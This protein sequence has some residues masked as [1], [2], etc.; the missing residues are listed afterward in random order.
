MLRNLVLLFL[1]AA[2]AEAQDAAPRSE[3]LVRVWQSDE[4]LPGN[5]VRS[6]GESADG[7]LWIATAEGISRFDG[8]SFRTVET[9]GTRRDRKYDYFR[10]FTPDDGSVWVATHSYGLFRVREDGLESAY[11]GDGGAEPGVV[12]RVLSHGGS[13]YF[14]R[15]GKLWRIGGNPPEA[16]DHPAP[17]LEAAFSTDVQRQ[18]QRG[19]GENKNLPELLVDRNGGEW[20]IR[21]RSLSYRAPGAASSVVVKELEGRVAATDMLEDREGSIWLANPSYGLV[22]IRHRRV[23]Q[24]PLHNGVYDSPALAAVQSKDGTWWIA[25]RNGGVDRVRDGEVFH[26][27][28]VTS[29]LVRAVACLKED[30]QG[31]LWIAT[32]DASV[33]LLN[34]ETQ[35]V[36]GQF[37]SNPELSKINVIVEDSNGR[38]WFGG[39]GRLFCWDG[40]KVESYADKP[41]LSGME[42]F[43]MAFAPSGILY[44][45]TTDGRMFTFDGHAFLPLGGLPHTSTRACIS[46][47]IPVSSGEVW[48]STIGGGILLWK[49]GRWHRFGSAQ[50]IPDERLT[51][52]TLEDG[53]SLWMGSLGGILHVSR[54]DLIDCVDDGKKFPRWLHLDRSDGLPTRECVGGSRPCVFRANDGSLWFPTTSGLAGLNPR[55]METPPVPPVIVF[56]PVEINGVSHPVG[57]A[58]IVAG[59]GFVRLGLN[60]TGVS[61]SAPEKVTYQV[62][63]VGLEG[64]PRFI[65][66]H[67][68]VD[69]QPVPPGRYRF[70]VS[71][72]NGEGVVSMHPAV[73]PIEVRPHFWQSIWF[74]ITTIVGGLALALAMGWLIAR[75]RM[76]HRLR[77]IRVHGMLE[78]ERSRISRDLHDELGASLTEVSIL[79]ELAAEANHD[80]KLGTS[81]GQ[82]SMKARQAVGALDEIV[83]ATNPAQDS[84]ASLVEYLAF[85]TREF[86]K[87]VDIPLHTDIVREVPEAMIGP[88]RRHHVVLATREALNN[89]VKYAGSESI[90][91]RIAIEDG[92]LVVRIRDE[93]KGFPIEYA[94][95]GNGLAN[96]RKRMSD[97][98]G[99]CLIDSIPGAGTTVTLSLPL[100]P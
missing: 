18:Q 17:D 85:S 4:G 16:V 100:P 38:L 27:P 90:S 91:L 31:R 70:E 83:W 9:G 44:L 46:S 97:C 99:D 43:C 36:E 24:L 26:V 37:P 48:A 45:G 86:L 42:I 47:V 52:L 20:S 75:S 92:K 50:G 25:N 63:L 78:A 28:I 51:T 87:A 80:E 33:Y 77:E 39:N 49:D 40:S 82:L 81:L 35:K 1:F 61:L 96:M 53:D 58:P 76:K 60:F 93:G 88:R 8:L 2:M 7:R 55:Q 73:L 66:N 23:I 67:R 74:I 11:E 3:F 6:I 57:A 30:R 41:E 62:R 54:Q 64:A 89:A 69:Y 72:T 95:G 19:R 12:T 15:K 13:D 65:G 21:N 59:P 98:G 94:T 84:L 14:V 5:V 29:G 34:P 79:T 22:R 56:E 10:I 71:A 68:E 32:R